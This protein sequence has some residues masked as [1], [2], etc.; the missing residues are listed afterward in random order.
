MTDAETKAAL[1]AL[2]VEYDEF[3]KQ[4]HDR[5]MEIVGGRKVRIVSN[6]NGQ[7][8]GESR[9]SRYGQEFT[10]DQVSVSN[11]PSWVYIGIAEHQY[12]APPRL[13]EVE[14]LEA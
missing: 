7:P 6:W 4:L 11:G 9:P 2:A 8:F 10:V 13:N 1:T 5:A 14:F 3:C 12:D